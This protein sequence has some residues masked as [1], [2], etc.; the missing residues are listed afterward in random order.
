MILLLDKSSVNDIFKLIDA[1]K[2]CIVF[3]YND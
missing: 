3:A 1:G 2:G